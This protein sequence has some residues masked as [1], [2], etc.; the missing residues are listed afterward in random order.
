MTSTSQLVV[1][2]LIVHLCQ[3]PSTDSLRKDCQAILKSRLQKVYPDARVVERIVQFATQSDH[4]TP[5]DK[6]L[7]E[8]ITSLNDIEAEERVK[9][10]RILNKFIVMWR[11]TAPEN[12]GPEWGVKGPP[13]MDEA[14]IVDSD[15]TAQWAGWPRALWSCMQG[16]GEHPTYRV[17]RLSGYPACDPEMADVMTAAGVEVFAT[18][19]ERVD[20]PRPTKVFFSRKNWSDLSQPV[21]A[22][23]NPTAP[24]Q[25]SE[26]YRE[27]QQS[28]THPSR[29]PRRTAVPFMPQTA[30]ASADVASPVSAQAS[31][32]RMRIERL[33]KTALGSNVSDPYHHLDDRFD[34]W[35]QLFQPIFFVSPSSQQCCPT[36]GFNIEAVGATTYSHLEQFHRASSML[37]RAIQE[38][39]VSA[40][41]PVVGFYNGLKHDQVHVRDTEMVVVGKDEGVAGGEWD[42][43][44]FGSRHDP[45]SFST[46]T[47]QSDTTRPNNT[48][49]PYANAHIKETMSSSTSTS[50]KGIVHLVVHLCEEPQTTSRRID[51]ATV[52][53]NRLKTLYPSVEVRFEASKFTFMRFIVPQI[54]EATR[55]YRHSKA[56]SEDATQGVREALIA[57]QDLEKTCIDR[58][59]LVFNKYIIL[60]RSSKITTRLSWDSSADIVKDIRKTAFVAPENADAWEGWPPHLVYCIRGFG[61]PTY[62]GQVVCT[63][64]GADVMMAAGLGKVKSGS[65]P[66]YDTK[67]KT[68]MTGP[69]QPTPRA[70]PS[71]LCALKPKGEWGRQQLLASQPKGSFNLGSS[72]K[73]KFSKQEIAASSYTGTSAGSGKRKRSDAASRVNDEG[74]A[75][76]EPQQKRARATAPTSGAAQSSKRSGSSK[77]TRAAETV[78]EGATTP[79]APEASPLMRSVAS[80]MTPSRST[81][82]VVVRPPVM[83]T[84]ISFDP[85]APGNGPSAPTL[86]TSTPPLIRGPITHGSPQGA[87]FV[88]PSV[89]KRKRVEEIDASVD[90]VAQPQ[91]KQR[92]QMASASASNANNNAVQPTETMREAVVGRRSHMPP[93]SSWSPTP[94]STAGSSRCSS[95]AAMTPLVPDAQIP[96]DLHA[97]AH[98]SQAPHARRPTTSLVNASTTA[99]SLPAGIPKPPIIAADVSLEDFVP[100]ELP[101]AQARKTH[102]KD[103][104]RSFEHTVVSADTSNGADEGYEFLDSDVDSLF[105]GPDDTVHLVE[106]AF[107]ETRRPSTV[108][109]NESLHEAAISHAGMDIQDM[110][111][112]AGEPMV[113]RSFTVNTFPT[114]LDYYLV[115]TWRPLEE[116]PYIPSEAAAGYST[117]TPLENRSESIYGWFS[118]IFNQQSMR[119]FVIVPRPV[120]PYEMRPTG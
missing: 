86:N 83:A 81:P 8:L 29:K 13:F 119:E 88:G 113:V 28:W 98:I 96:V 56:G 39:T 92:K 42:K 38:K 44:R 108:T 104:A 34:H 46:A 57:M 112:Q 99:L 55:E 115:E 36:F 84:D 73:V 72:D 48:H 76:A 24:S 120:P 95:L 69:R 20:R 31:A 7:D 15:D 33:A 6:G 47:Y 21:E 85:L 90:D 22:A 111:W 97:T 40:V 102:E 109:I 71:A 18:C 23:S 107:T 25:R 19:E 114:P 17:S 58:R 65:R 3:D 110:G 63:F 11:L 37:A 26:W 79:Q 67:V 66:K 82:T 64:A 32:K 116:N 61:T 30:I 52:L 41:V 60:W 53:D 78:T 118:S 100:R 5:V 93:P 106:D 105:D 74:V 35:G 77:K 59:Q 51:C 50:S 80:T 117:I 75:A 43:A 54:E 45:S 14:S 87:A 12:R 4:A 62:R 94:A 49:Y 91:A 70:P 2:H 1:E 16:L 101:N 9:G 27:V 103:D 10:R 68:T 89:L